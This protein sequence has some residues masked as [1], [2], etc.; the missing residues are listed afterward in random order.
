MIKLPNVCGQKGNDHSG[1]GTDKSRPVRC[2]GRKKKLKYVVGRDSSHIAEHR[3][4]WQ[5][6]KPHG[7]RERR[8]YECSNVAS[9]YYRILHV[10]VVVRW[11]VIHGHGSDCYFRAPTMK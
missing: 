7:P 11:R 5:V 1:N 3:H 10:Y 2:Y 9:P 4:Y 6:S 8:A